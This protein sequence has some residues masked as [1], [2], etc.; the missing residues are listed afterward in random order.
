MTPRLRFAQSRCL[1]AA[2][3]ALSLLGVAV[4]KVSASAT[5]EIARATSLRGGDVESV[6]SGRFLAGFAAV[7]AGVKRDAVAP[8]VTAAV[9][10]RSD[11]APR[12]TGAALNAHLA[13]HRQ[14]LTA[15]ESAYVL[16]I[17]TAAM[18]ATPPSAA[19]GIAAAAIA[20]QPAAREQII[21]IALAVAPGQK[22]SIL[23]ATAPRS[24]AFAWL[25][26]AGPENSAAPASAGML[27]PANLDGRRDQDVRSP[28]KMP[29]PHHG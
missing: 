6:R 27:N 19:A 29:R 24:N 10:L 9:T 8:Y 14:S 20:I 22:S 5:D 17:V 26:G 3:L 16:Q 23:A 12:I 21:A 2:T 18:Q 11:L 4:R 7:V 15:D 13:S 25:G 1:L 28:E